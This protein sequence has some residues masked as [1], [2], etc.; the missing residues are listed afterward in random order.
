MK[1]EFS[2]RHQAIKMRLAGQSVE[3]IC[4]TL[5]RSREWF[6]TWWR[7]YQ[8]LGV[9]GLYDLTR[10]R[11]RASL[12]SPEMERMILSIR[13]RLESTYHPQ[14]RYALIGA[15]AIQAELKSL[16]IRAVRANHRTCVATKWCDLAQSTLGTFPAYA[17]L[18]CAASVR[19]QSL[20]SGGLGWS[21]LPE[22][23]EAALLHLHLQRRF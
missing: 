19:F 8:A 9:A 7:R 4:Q 2:D 1:D 20:A 11:Q 18:P 22:R 5:E 3:V 13:K 6:H 17:C 23:A 10:A 15:S 14:T 12:I 16:N 21:D